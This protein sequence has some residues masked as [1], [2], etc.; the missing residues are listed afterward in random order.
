[1][2]TA[3][4]AALILSLSPLPEVIKE[5][6]HKHLS[7]KA[8]TKKGHAIEK[9]SRDVYLDSFRRALKNKGAKPDEVAFINSLIYGESGG[10]PLAQGPLPPGGKRHIWYC[11]LVQTQARTL[12]E[13]QRVQRD[14]GYAAEVAL[15]I[16]HYQD[17]YPGSRWCNWKKGPNHI[18]CRRI[19]AKSIPTS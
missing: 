9:F 13:C 11:G 19:R 12:G 10:D 18:D 1:M 14:P 8:L 6:G 2:L 3:L 17:K 5:S 16:L 4:A 7:H 15:Q